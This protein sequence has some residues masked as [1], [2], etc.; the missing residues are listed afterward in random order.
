MN[1]AAKDPRVSFHEQC[2]DPISVLEK[3]DVLLVPSRWA[4]FSQ[5]ACSALAAQRTVLA[6]PVDGLCD[7]TELGVS[8][9]P[10]H[11]QQAWSAA[12]ASAAGKVAS[13]VPPKASIISFGDRF[14]QG[15]NR[16]VHTCQGDATQLA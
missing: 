15:W 10:D 9:V 5:I 4:P 3:L 12:I 2:D 11:S 16:L 6:A 8:I 7:L 14:E 1:L 13:P